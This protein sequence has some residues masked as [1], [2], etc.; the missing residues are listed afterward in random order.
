MEVHVRKHIEDKRKK[1]DPKEACKYIEDHK[2]K[3]EKI[4]SEMA[5]ACFGSPI[6]I[7]KRTTRGRQRSFVEV[8][9]FF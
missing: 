7:V 3:N 2:K 9:G 8:Y 6:D 5:V 4:I 1:Y